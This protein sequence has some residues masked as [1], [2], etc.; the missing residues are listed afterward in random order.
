MKIENFEDI[1]AWQEARS[2]TN[3]IYNFTTDGEFSKDY[4][5]RDQIQR[6]SASIMANIACPVE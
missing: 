1:E 4:G 2:L 6:A 3:A 5:L